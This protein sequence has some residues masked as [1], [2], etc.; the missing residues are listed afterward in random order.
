[1][2]AQALSGITITKNG[3]ITFANTCSTSDLLIEYL[4]GETT[5]AILL[6]RVACIQLLSRRRESPGDFL[7]RLTYLAEHAT[8]DGAQLIVFPAYTAFA[9]LTL[10]YP[11]AQL[12]FG[13]GLAQGIRRIWPSYGASNFNEFL[14]F[15]KGLARKHR[16]YIVPGTML[17]PTGNGVTNTSYLISPAGTTI[18]TQQQTHLNRDERG[19][20]FVNGDDLQVFATPLGNL[21]FA[22]CE[23]AWY[24]EV[25]RILTLKGAQIIIAPIAVPKPYSKWHQVRGMWQNIQQNQVFGIESC[26]TGFLG[27]VEFEGRST[28]YAT[29]EMTPGDTGVLAQAKAAHMEDVF[30]A[31]LDF[32]KLGET[33]RRFDIFSQFN[34][35]LYKQWFPHLYREYPPH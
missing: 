25:V 14:D 9:Y 35:P 17:T 7:L 1:M 15:F 11:E 12:Y 21:G 4:Q 23:D 34:V 28:I 18:G 30:T 29:C 3:T 26:L 16:T 33:I 31:G 32:I 6:T 5:E 19:S 27:G 8:Y 24:P 13:P 20:G 2:S 22:I 10:A